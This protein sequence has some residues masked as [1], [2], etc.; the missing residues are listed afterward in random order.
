V[1]EGF[2][3]LGSRL[4]NWG[5]WGDDDERGTLNHITPERLAHAAGLARRGKVIEL[6]IPFD[7]EGPQAG[8]GR[9][10]PIHL[11]SVVGGVEVD[12]E[13]N[14]GV[15]RYNDDYAILPLQC[16][17]QWDGLAHVYYDDLLYN[18]FPADAV[19]T[20]GAA[21]VSIDRLGPGVLGR[22]V[23]IDVARHRGVDW[24]EAGEAIGPEELEE[25]AR[26]QGVEL[27]PG[28]VLLVRTG[29]WTK[30]VTERSRRT[31]LAAEP[32]L[33]LECAEWLREREVAALAVDNHAVEVLPNAHVGTNYPLHLVLIRDMGMT[34][35]E[36]FDLDALA[37]DSAA[38]GVY[39]SFLCAPLL[40]VSGAV[41]TPLSPLALK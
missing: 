11:M 3:E 19:S 2:R 31:I 1:A 5:R 13:G 8:A 41:G 33:G 14:R 7:A 16:A 30:A 32:G 9:I 38:D 22:G 27:L 10:N 39:E 37:A 23:L 18:G 20:S 17:T 6:G 35:G 21:R 40:K 25:T 34:L 12:R 28:D 4:S 29:W 15:M 24:L 26:A 36:W